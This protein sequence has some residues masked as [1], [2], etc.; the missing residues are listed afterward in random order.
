M[1]RICPYCN[2]MVPA[3][4][5]YCNVCHQAIPA[6]SAPVSGGALTAQGGGS[7]ATAY[8]QAQ[9]GRSFPL[10]GRVTRIGRDTAS[11]VA[12]ADGQVSGRHAEVEHDA[13]GYVLRDLGSTNGTY[14]NG[15]RIAND[16][17]LSGGEQILVGN[18]WLTFY[19]GTPS[20]SGVGQLAKTQA[21]SLSSLQSAPSHVSSLQ[22]PQPQSSQVSQWQAQ[23]ISSTPQSPP[24]P[25]KGLWGSLTGPRVVGRVPFEPKEA[26]EQPP[27][28][29][30]RLMVMFV[31]MMMFMT[32]IAAFIAT[33][34]A[35]AIVLICLGAG[36]LLFIVPFLFMP[37]QQLFGGLMG[38]L[39][40]QKPVTVIRFRVDD[41]FTGRPVEVVLR[42]KMG[43]GGGVYQND[44][45]QIWGSLR[46]GTLYASTVRVEDSGAKIRARKPWPLWI[47][48]LA[49]AGIAAQAYYLF[50][51]VQGP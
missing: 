40:D 32:A 17:R 6:H 24:Q 9:D 19:L 18:S 7:A 5:M 23:Q 29:F 31:V 13:S 47:G 22:M 15:Q 36:A 34:M 16:C 28:D 41:D 21:A 27:T 37:L 38:W 11:D 42:R 20:S 33:I 4:A 3:G 35:V 1:K 12:L 14:V 8:L 51:L 30:S 48:L 44:R 49:L 39:K 26:Q 2:A 25:S 45:V 10:T 50:T 46:G 43:E